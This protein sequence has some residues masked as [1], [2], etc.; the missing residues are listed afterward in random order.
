MVNFYGPKWVSYFSSQAE[1][2]LAAAEAAGY[3]I[4]P[5]GDGR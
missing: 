3:V 2:A 4:A 5:P 1:A